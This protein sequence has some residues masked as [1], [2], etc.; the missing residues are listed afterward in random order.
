MAGMISDW[1]AHAEQSHLAR[2]IKALRPDDLDEWLDA[3]TPRLPETVRLNPLRLDQDWTR[4]C[5]HEMGA[6]PIEWYTGD[7]GAFCLPWEKGRCPDETNKKRIQNL[8]ATG[9]IT[10][11]EAASMLPVQ[12]L[13]IQPGH[14]VL[15]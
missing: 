4:Q 10:Q 1:R 6:T 12:A 7:G 3:A 11:Q 15:D 2:L 8:H 13:D 14:R 5:L 9:R